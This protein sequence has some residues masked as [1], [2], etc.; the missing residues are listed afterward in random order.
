MKGCATS[1]IVC[2][3]MRPAVTVPHIDW[4]KNNSAQQKKSGVQIWKV[5]QCV[6]LTRRCYVP[7]LALRRFCRATAEV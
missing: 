3:I 6:P 2:T 7:C 1:I 5:G 4:F